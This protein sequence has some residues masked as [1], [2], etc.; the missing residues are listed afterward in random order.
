MSKELILSDEVYDIEYDINFRNRDLISFENIENY[1]TDGEMVLDIRKNY[2]NKNLYHIRQLEEYKF[3]AL[4]KPFIEKEYLKKVLQIKN[5]VGLSPITYR[6]N[7]LL[8]SCINDHLIGSYYV[9][10]LQCLQLFYY[11]NKIFFFV[12]NE[13]NEDMGINHDSYMFI[14]FVMGCNEVSPKT[15]ENLTILKE[16]QSYLNSM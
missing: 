2:I 9:N 3:N 15:K 1:L 6:G 13:A 10:E 12:L 4:I 14:G 11:E 8:R 5:M 7:G 16:L